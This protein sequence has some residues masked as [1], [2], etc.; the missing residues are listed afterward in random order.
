MA[1]MRLD[2]SQPAFPSGLGAKMGIDA[3]KPLAKEFPP[4]VESPKEVM[5]MV[6]AQWDSYGI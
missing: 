3:T 1:G 6:A 5:D 4:L 2:P